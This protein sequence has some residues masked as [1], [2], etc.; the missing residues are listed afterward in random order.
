[1]EVTLSIC[2]AQKLEQLERLRGQM[3]AQEFAGKCFEAGLKMAD[4]QS[5]Q[6]QHQFA[7]TKPEF[8]TLDVAA[9][10]EA[11]KAN[12]SKNPI[13]MEISRLV[14]AYMA[15]LQDV[16]RKNGNRLPSQMQV[17]AQAP[18]ER[19]AFQITVE[20]VKSA[21]QR[22][23]KSQASATQQQVSNAGAT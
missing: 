2:D 22:G 12:D 11:L 1:M 5:R 13:T 10:E 19:L 15:G 23:A 20:A 4:I 17:A 9:I 3:T 6:K 14:T 7:G 16:A 8:K 21:V 18:I